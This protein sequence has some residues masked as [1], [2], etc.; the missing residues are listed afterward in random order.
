MMLQMKH[1]LRFYATVA[2]GSNRVLTSDKLTALTSVLDAFS[3]CHTPTNQQASRV[4][5]LM[6]LDFDHMA[7]VCGVT[8]QV[9]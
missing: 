5:T 3:T 2:S 7:A 4:A 8:I 6:T 1:A 9:R